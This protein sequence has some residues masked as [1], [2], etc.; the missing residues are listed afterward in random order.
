MK[1]SDASGDGLSA[2]N[3]RTQLRQRVEQNLLADLQWRRLAD[4]GMHS[5]RSST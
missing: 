2:S 5:S 3:A 1:S 4:I